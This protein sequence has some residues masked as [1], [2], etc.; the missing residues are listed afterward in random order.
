[1]ILT[2]SAPLLKDVQIRYTTDGS[3]P[4][5]ASPLYDKPLTLTKSAEVRAT[6]FRDGKPVSLVGSGT[7]VL[8]PP[9]PPAPDVYLAELKPMSRQYPHAIWHYW[10]KV[11]HSHDGVPLSIRGQTYRHGLGMRAPANEQYELKADYERF[12]GLAGVDDGVLR[13]AENGRFWAMHASVQF[14]VFVDGE[15]AAESPILR[16]S[17]GPW[18]FDVKLPQGARRIDLVAADAGSRSPYD[19][20]NWVEAGFIRKGSAGQ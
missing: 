1:M 3:E 7:Y 16:I 9:A 10:P 18:P 15:L 17:Q 4:T 14:R 5:A 20:G 2:L 13:Q 19:L 8:L 11:D 12:V 6:A